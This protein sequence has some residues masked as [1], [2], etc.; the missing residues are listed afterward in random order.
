MDI[1][2]TNIE[3]KG[4]PVNIEMWVERDI[5]DGR[6]F[7]H[8]KMPI[9]DRDSGKADF[10]HTVS[11]DAPSSDLAWA[12]DPARAVA[13]VHKTLRSMLLHELD[14]CFVVDGKRV[15]DPHAPMKP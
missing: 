12:A 9:A 5:Y 11:V 3:L 7:L 10:L 13:F 6:M 4:F 1:L 8:C 2:G 14:E 15:F